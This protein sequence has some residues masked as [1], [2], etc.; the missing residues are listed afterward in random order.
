MKQILASVLVFIMIFS[1]AGCVT[2]RDNIIKYHVYKPIQHIYI[3]ISEV[4]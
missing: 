4:K 2:F 1:L 3:Y